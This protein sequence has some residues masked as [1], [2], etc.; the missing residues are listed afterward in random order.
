M[1]RTLLLGGAAAI[2]LVAVPATAQI[3]ADAPVAG[4]AASVAA[5]PTTAPRAAPR[6][7]VQPYIEAAQTLS[8]DLNDGDAVTYTQLSAGIDA[9][10]QTNR[11]Q[12]QVSYRYDH[13]F[14][15]E[16]GEGDYDVHTGLARASLGLVRGLSLEA[17][18]LATRARSDIRGAAPENL[19][20]RTDNTSQL[21]AAYVGPTL[22]T[23]A[24]PLA[25]NAF[26]QAGYTKVE[27]PTT[28]GDGPDARRL[29]YYNDSWSHNVGGS[30]GTQANTLLPVGIT[31]S[32]LYTRETA[33]QLSQRFEGWFGR[34]DLLVPV[35]PTVALAGGVGYEKIETS[36]KDPL[37]TSPGAPALDEDGR[38][39][40][41]PNS[42]RRI[43]YRTDGVYY[44]AGVVWR[45]NRRTELRGSV[46]RRYGSTSYTGSLTYQASRNIGYSAVVYDTVTTFGRQLRTGL[47]NT[48]TSFRIQRDPFGQQFGGC[49]FGTTGASPGGCFDDVFQ[50]IST[51]SYRARGVE[52]VAV[53]T[54][55]RSTFGAGLGY[56]NRKLYAPNTGSGIVVYGQE[57]ESVYGQLFYSRALTGNSSVDANLFANYYDSE[58]QGADGVWSGGGQAAYNHQFGRLGATAA[59]GLYA[60]KVGDFAT[61]WAAQALLGARYTF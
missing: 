12:A 49:V 30:I 15:W 20:G 37:Y 51:A 55:G 54:Y 50:S 39:V 19:L 14:A 32:G 35:S 9:A 7:T 10:V 6:V 60:F 38:F 25:V 34:G 56:A 46:G 11:V 2:A 27:T 43:A 36:Q 45:P 21:Y 53:A 59:V 3:V 4:P 29:D 44:D 24:G 31:V 23:T 16:D 33:G 1:I 40:T 5:P 58:L 61:E 42:P 28:T 26:Y 57:D 22:S 48:P 18:G 8:W 17:G 52:G 13:L 47:A 41:D